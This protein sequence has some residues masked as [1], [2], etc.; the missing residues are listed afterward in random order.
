MPAS[1]DMVPI[2]TSLN[3]EGGDISFGIGP[4][5]SIRQLGS[6]VIACVLWLF[7]GY[8][9]L[10]ALIGSIL[11]GLLFTCPLPI[12]GFIIAFKKKDGLPY[13]YY[14]ANKV[15]KMVDGDTYVLRSRTDVQLS[16][17]KWYDNDEETI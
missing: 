17:L 4:A 16:Q 14:L 1:G 15:I 8:A 7:L 6:I 13:E 5:I 11:I 3:E 12:A 9:L 2:P 10:G